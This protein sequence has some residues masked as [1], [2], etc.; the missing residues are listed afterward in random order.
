MKQINKQTD[1]RSLT[2]NTECGHSYLIVCTLV[3][4]VGSLL[5]Q[6][7]HMIHMISHFN[8]NNH[9]NN[10]RR[11]SLDVC[12]CLSLFPH[13]LFPLVCVCLCLCMYER[14][15]TKQFSSPHEY[16]HERRTMQKF[17]QKISYKL[18]NRWIC[19]ENHRSY[20]GELNVT[21]IIYRQYEQCC[22]D[23]WTY[24]LHS[25]CDLQTLSKYRQ[26]H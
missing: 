12:L 22:G 26:T 16:K 23:S 1:Y 5:I 24:P 3:K 6:I 20:T 4:V 21:T 15:L 8:N 17:D 10:N 13:S 11:N 18:M 25:Y 2:R 19:N 9:N 7:G 14:V